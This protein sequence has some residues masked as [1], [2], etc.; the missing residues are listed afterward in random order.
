[1]ASLENLTFLES[2]SLAK[3][4]IF[5]AWSPIRSISLTT[6]KYAAIVVLCSSP[7]SELDSLTRYLVIS[8]SNRFIKASFLYTLFI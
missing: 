1:M 6:W 7:I 5:S 2:L 4:A 3:S 8:V